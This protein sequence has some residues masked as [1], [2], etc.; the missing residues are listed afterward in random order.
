MLR[1]YASRQLVKTSEYI[2]QST[3]RAVLR[4]NMRENAWERYEYCSTYA[5]SAR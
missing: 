1:A 5:L 2:G 4:M 3:L